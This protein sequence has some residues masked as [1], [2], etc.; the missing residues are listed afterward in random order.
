VPGNHEG[1]TGRGEV[2][3]TLSQ[4]KRDID[5]LKP[6]KGGVNRMHGIHCKGIVF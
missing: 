4:D 5:G 2:R 3:Q 6:E 1:Q